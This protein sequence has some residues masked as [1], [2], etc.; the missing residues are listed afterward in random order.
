MC[1]WGG[2]RFYLY[3]SLTTNTNHVE[4]FEKIHEARKANF[5]IKLAIIS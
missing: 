4:M 1:V 5:P 3:L 2:G